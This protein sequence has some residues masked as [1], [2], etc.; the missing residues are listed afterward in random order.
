MSDPWAEL[1]DEARAFEAWYLPTPMG[2]NAYVGV[3]TGSGFYGGWSVNGDPL[4]LY[5]WDESLMTTAEGDTP[6]AVIVDLIKI[7]RSYRERCDA[8]RAEE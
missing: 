6:E 1:M 5:E 4:Y 2:V 3:D 7:A 8:E